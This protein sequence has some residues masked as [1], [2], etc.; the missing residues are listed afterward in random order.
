MLVLHY[1]LQYMSRHE[2]F[3]FCFAQRKEEK[4][5]NPVSQCSSL[6]E[7]G[8][9]RAGRQPSSQEFE[10][11]LLEEIRLYF[12]LSPENGKAALSFVIGG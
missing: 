8:K 10:N 9:H 3:A 5:Y 7:T 12:Y 1:C 6:A 2:V 11:Q 4:Q